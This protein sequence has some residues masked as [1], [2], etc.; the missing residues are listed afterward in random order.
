M[1]LCL[2]HN[3]LVDLDSRPCNNVIILYFVEVVNKYFVSMSLSKVNEDLQKERDKCSFDVAELTHLIDGGQ[4]KTLDR[5]KKGMD[6]TYNP[7]ILS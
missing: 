4:E 6:S 2:Y 5:R 1:F 7:Q 3:M